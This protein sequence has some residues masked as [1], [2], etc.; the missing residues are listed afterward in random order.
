MVEVAH[1][2][3]RTHTQ[4]PG[5][6]KQIARRAGKK[7]AKVA[8]ARKLLVAGWCVL[9]RNNV[10]RQASTEQVACA[11]FALAYK[12]GVRN[13]PDGMSAFKYVRHNL[14]MLGIGQELTHIPWG[15][16]RYKL[17]ASGRR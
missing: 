15:T 2:A 14:D 11:F 3:A 1:S 17:P 6:F 10:D 12:I 7:K 16:K 8:I 9:V 13:L 5:V 4:W